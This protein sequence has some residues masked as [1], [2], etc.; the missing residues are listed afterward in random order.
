MGV[1]LSGLMR[2]EVVEEKV[3][4]IYVHIYISLSSI[5]IMVP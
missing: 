3:G 2:S 1:K 4:C 5:A